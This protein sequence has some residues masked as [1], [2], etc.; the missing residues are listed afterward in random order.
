MFVTAL[1]YLKSV[2]D[3]WSGTSANPLASWSKTISVDK[4]A[5]V[6]GFSEIT[7][8][9][10]A[11]AAPNAHMAITGTK[12]GSNVTV[13]VSIA[14]KYGSLGLLAPS[15]SGLTFN[16]DG[17]AP[18]PGEFTDIDDSVH[19][20]DIGVIADLGITKGCNP[21]SNTEFCPL[22]DVTRG[23]MAAFLNRALSLPAAATDYFSDDDSSIFESDINRLVAHAGIDLACS[24]GL[25]CPDEPI[26]RDEMALF[27]QRAF[28]LQS[29]SDA[30]FVDAVGN[31]YEAEINI[32]AGTGISKGCNPPT[33]D[34]FCPDG[35]VRRQEMA[36]FL[37]RA[38]KFVGG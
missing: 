7:N 12:S 14:K 21:P 13:Q 24:E 16:P 23:Q 17:V 33:N 31:P 37:V 32:L 6:Y 11:D 15:V 2:S 28:D 1:P 36:S 5:S 35:K 18:S 29:T 38:I 8:V 27:L 3:P 30:Q 19:R 20:Y 10:L 25:F 22:L 26:R 34:E 9:T 4:I